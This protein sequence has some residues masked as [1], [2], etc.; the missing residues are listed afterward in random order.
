MP[1]VRERR[2]DVAVADDVGARR[3]SAGRIT[4]STSC[5]RAAAKSAASAHGEMSRPCRAAARGCARRAPCRPARAS[6]RRRGPRRAAPRRAAPPASTCR[7]RRFPRR[8]RTLRRQDTAR[9]AANE[10]ASVDSSYALRPSTLALAHGDDRRVRR[11][12]RSSSPLLVAIGVTVLGK[13]VAHRVQDAA[14]SKV[15]GVPPVPKAPRRRGAPRAA[16][17]RDGRARPQR[18]RGRRRRRRDGGRALRA[19][20]YLITGVGNARDAVE[21]DAHARDVPPRLPRRGARLARDAHA[22]TRLAA[23][24]HAPQ[25]AD[26]RAGRPRRRPLAS[27]D[28]PWVRPQP[29]LQETCTTTRWTALLP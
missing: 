29:C 24:R 6:R 8:S 14:L 17:R 11:S 10:F 27:Q 23:R 2:V 26:G 3:A 21:R 5:A 28:M 19:R 20:G 12:R 22:Q 16:A 15:A 1:L 13:S 18:Q 4:S 9:D 7:C 25:R